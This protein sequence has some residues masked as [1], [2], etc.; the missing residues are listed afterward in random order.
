[1]TATDL[2]FTGERFVPGA[3]GEM[4]YE[5]W[6][7]YAFAREFV[8]D[9]RVLDA[10]CGEGYG[11][12]LL[13]AGAATATGVDI[14]A[15]TV[16][17]ARERYASRS[18][19]R[20]EEGSVAALPFADASF[21][22]VV[23]FET[24]EHVSAD[25][26]VRMLAEFSRVLAPRGLLIISSPNKRL[27][28]EARNYRNPFH[29][30]ELNRDE[31]ARLLDAGFPHRR[32]FLQTRSY[33]S[34]LWSEDFSGTKASCDV[35]I[36]DGESVTNASA[37]DGLY[38]LVIAAAIA[39]ALP[40]VTAKMSLFSDRED[41]EWQRVEAATREILRLDALLKDRDA[42]ADR[43]MAHI[44]HLEQL[45]AYR[46]RIVEERDAQLAEVNA[47][48]EG[49]ERELQTERPRYEQARKELARCQ[50]EVAA[51]KRTIASLQ[52]EQGSLQAA[53]A[54]QE[55]IISHRQSLRWWLRLPW[56]RA[57][58]SWQHWRGQ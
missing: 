53:L 1:M 26:Q 19:V 11:T 28:S 35:W 43:Q 47:L 4:A 32:W 46:E 20:F 57:K 44:Q 21:D 30:H 34:A 14:D 48:R 6:H 39:D 27:Y 2:E 8:R 10:A 38:Y 13:A 49:H 5:H 3:A 23:S 9:K 52:G 58:L 7:R 36:G 54:A 22:V 51:L 24:I 15:A 37:P 42:A 41:S 16:A 12:A 18:N 45:V 50:A 55:R 40:V 29:L 17:H 25:D 31:L 56:V 33:A